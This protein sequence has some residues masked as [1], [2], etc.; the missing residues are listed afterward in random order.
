MITQYVYNENQHM[1]LLALRDAVAAGQ[2]PEVVINREIFEECYLESGMMARLIG[3]EFNTSE[4][5]GDGN[6]DLCYKLTFD[7]KEFD[8]HN[9][10]L[11][12][13]DWWNPETNAYDLTGTESGAKP[14]N[15]VESVY[16]SI[17]HGKI[18]FDVVDSRVTELINAYEQSGYTSY[19]AWL[20]SLLIDSD[21]LSKLKEETK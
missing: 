5:D 14:S 9:I 7:F 2:Y 3:L 6:E 12:S 8:K 1:Y 21:I 11:E 19:V 17:T 10:A 13:A 4:T 16:H 20:E 18:C 15:F